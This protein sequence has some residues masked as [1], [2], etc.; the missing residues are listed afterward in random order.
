MIAT[1]TPITAPACIPFLK[2]IIFAQLPK[3]MLSKVEYAK[4]DKIS[5]MK[6]EAELDFLNPIKLM[7]L[8]C[9]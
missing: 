2:L 8:D 9:I 7:V 6:F 4:Q 3:I 5:I 1:K